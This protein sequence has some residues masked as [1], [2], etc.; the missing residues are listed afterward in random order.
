MHSVTDASRVVLITAPIATDWLEHLQSL[1]PDLHI[2]HWP[3]ETHGQPPRERWRDVEILYTSFATQLPSPEYAPHLRCIQFYSAGIDSVLHHP[4]LQTTV[5]CTT[6]SGVHAVTIA[7]YVFAVVLAWFHRVPCIIE[8]QRWQRWPGP[9]ERAAL[10]SQEELA[11][12]TIGI[13]GYGS[14]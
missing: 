1:S 7:E 14:V 4:L 10:F 6:A 12:K 11:G 13:V 8:W 2:E 3:V 5:S 9:T